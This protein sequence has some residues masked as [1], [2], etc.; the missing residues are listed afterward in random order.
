MGKA[1]KIFSENSKRAL[2]ERVQKRE[3]ISTALLEGLA[4]A[5]RNGFQKPYDVCLSIQVELKEAGFNIV[6]K[7]S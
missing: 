2:D 7:K 6:R 1:G 3:D 4:R 5:K